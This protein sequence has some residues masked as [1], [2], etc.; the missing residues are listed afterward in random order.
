MAAPPYRPTI[1]SPSRPLG[2]IAALEPE[3][4]GLIQVMRGDPI[5][6][7][8]AL[9][10]RVFHAGPLWGCDCVLTLA[11]VGKV[12]AAATASALIHRF[13][14]SGIVF[15]GVAGGIGAEVA[16]GDVVVADALV[17]HDL[18]ASP[19]FP[20]YEVPLL[21]RA[22]FDTDATL[23]ARLH[24]ASAGFL[25]DD[26]PG[27]PEATRR[28]FRLYLPRLHRGLVAS[29]DQFVHDAHVAANLARELSGIL[30]VEMEGAAVAQVCFEHGVPFALMRTISDR[31]DAEAPLD[32][33]AFLAEV[34][35][36]Y[37]FEILRRFLTS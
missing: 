31:A 32:F 36:A 35:S 24:D 25:Q 6:H 10:S 33:P 27:L 1:R 2:L 23:T 3:A 37:S 26:L 17:Q 9:G 19:I 28:R 4:A 20:R 22:L 16:I 7:Q 15:T 21:G 30:A 13:D 8:L 11:R 29:G 34:A 18:D 12:A 5:A 14:V